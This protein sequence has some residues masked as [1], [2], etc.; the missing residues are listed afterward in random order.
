MEKAV[1][2]TK[3]NEDECFKYKIYQ[4]YFLIHILTSSKMEK[5]GY[6]FPVELLL[7]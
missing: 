3:L 2:I 1:R 4:K 6:Q 5:Q 7:K